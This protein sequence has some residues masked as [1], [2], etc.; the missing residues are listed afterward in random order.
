CGASETPL[1]IAIQN[2]TGKAI[3]AVDQHPYPLTAQ[4]FME[5]A[6]SSSAKNDKRKG[7]G[8]RGK[9]KRGRR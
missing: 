2:L 3:P 6:A 9:G 5:A 1:L 8:K 7:S 4:D